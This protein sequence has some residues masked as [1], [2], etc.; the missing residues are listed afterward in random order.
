MD[1]ISLITGLPGLITTRA[2]LYKMTM[3]HRYRERDINVII[4]RVAI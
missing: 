4:D 1:V 2:D 3:T